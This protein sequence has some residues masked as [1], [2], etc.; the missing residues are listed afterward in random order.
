MGSQMWQARE[1]QEEMMARGI[2][3]DHCLN[4]LLAFEQKD[5]FPMVSIVTY[6]Q[7]LTSTEP[8]Q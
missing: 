8:L 7:P 3:W 2:D 6:N 4:E 1:G 5:G